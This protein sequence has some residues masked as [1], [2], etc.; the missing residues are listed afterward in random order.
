V[1][2]AHMP[3]NQPTNHTTTHLLYGHHAKKRTPRHLAVV[4]TTTTV[5]PSAHARVARL[6]VVVKVSHLLVACRPLHSLMHANRL[7]SFKVYYVFAKKHRE[8]PS[9]SSSYGFIKADTRLYLTRVYTPA[10]VVPRASTLF[11]RNSGSPSRRTTTRRSLIC[12]TRYYAR[13]SLSRGEMLTL[14]QRRSN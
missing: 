9:S 2:L 14:V 5:A 4:A 10:V 12:D 8:A 1:P 6:R 11:L 13:F 3:A 7:S